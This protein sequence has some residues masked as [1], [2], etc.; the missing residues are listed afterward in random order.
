LV[1][2][3]TLDPDLEQDLNLD[4][5]EMLDHP[6]SMNPDPQH[7]LKVMNNLN[8]LDNTVISEKVRRGRKLI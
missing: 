5:L 1:I 4:S 3:T 7:C 8:C 6:D 2:K